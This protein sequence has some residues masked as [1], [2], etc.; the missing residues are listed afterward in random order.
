LIATIA[1]VIADIDV[2]VQRKANPKGEAQRPLAKASIDF[3]QLGRKRKKEN[4]IPLVDAIEEQMTV[5]GDEGGH[6]E[7]VNK[8]IPVL[9]TLTEE[10]EHSND[11]SNEIERESQLLSVHRILSECMRQV[12]E[13][14]GAKQ[15][16]S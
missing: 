11:P 3:I 16:S 9:R 6:L 10:L 13:P 5:L 4:G 15:I 2:T 8:A 7:A 1:L 12:Y 14:G